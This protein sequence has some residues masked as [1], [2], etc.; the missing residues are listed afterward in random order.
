MQK[1]FQKV[2]AIELKIRQLLHKIESLDREN[3][4]LLK[5]NIRLKKDINQYIDKIEGLQKV[6]Q[7]VKPEKTIDKEEVKVRIDRLSSEV[8]ECIDLLKA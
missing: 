1:L 8:D 5:E 3:G 2:D 4:F 6:V 7:D